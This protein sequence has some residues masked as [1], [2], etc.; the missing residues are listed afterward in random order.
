MEHR[1]IFSN[2]CNI[3]FRKC[4]LIRFELVILYCHDPRAF[5]QESMKTSK[6][7]RG[8]GPFPF[9]EGCPW[10]AGD[11]QLINQFIHTEKKIILQELDNYLT[12]EA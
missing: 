7:R 12:H 9:H 11:I 6:N 3:L 8:V 4:D 2:L 5:S 10:W 1:N